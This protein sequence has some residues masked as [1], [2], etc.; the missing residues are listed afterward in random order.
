MT[1]TEAKYLKGFK[2]IKND[3]S[4]R[5]NYTM[6]ELLSKYRMHSMAGTYIIKRNYVHK[7]DGR[8]RWIGTNP[9]IRCVRGYLKDY[10][11]NYG[12]Q[13]NKSIQKITVSPKK[14]QVLVTK[15]FFGLITIR[16]K[17]S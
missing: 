17:W 15:L 6:T 4:S 12:S 9:S 1:S 8:W 16:S 3:L 10:K 13:A 11:E 14:K 2:A 7:I 5:K